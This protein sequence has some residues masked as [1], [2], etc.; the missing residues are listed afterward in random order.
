MRPLQLLTVFLILIFLL[1][2]AGPAPA[3]AASAA[4]ANATIQV[5]TFTD[6]T[7]PDGN[8]SLREA[9]AAANTDQAVDGCAKGSENDTLLLQAGK[10]TLA[11]GALDLSTALTLQG[12]SAT[13]TILDGGGNSRIFTIEN[14]GIVTLQSMTL[15]NG[16][17]KGRSGL[18]GGGGIYNNGY[19]TL[20]QVILSNNTS[21]YIGGAIDNRKSLTLLDV[22]FAQNQAV[23]PSNPAKNNTGGGVFNSGSLTANRVSF[24]GNHANTYGGGLDNNGA[25]TTAHLTNVTFSGNSASIGGGIHNDASEDLINVTLARNTAGTGANIADYGTTRAVNTLFADGAGSE[26]CDGNAIS[27][28][29]HNLDSGSSC[30]LSTTPSLADLSNT[31]PLLDALV[32]GSLAGYIPLQA[33]SPAIDSGDNGQCPLTDQ[34]K[35]A[36]PADGNRDGSK[37]CDR[38]AYELYNLDFHAYLPTIIR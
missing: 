21:D 2:A 11:H 8:C 30:K 13:G 14:T 23:D 32:S 10:Y 9:I 20:T 33:G 1:A 15:Q 35:L 4:S 29:G 18:E 17:Q 22:Q 31:D 3:S 24:T 6:E 38:G 26:N 12:V 34:R 19:L 16:A 25:G 28:L 27:S 7:T 36:R 5:N 37:I